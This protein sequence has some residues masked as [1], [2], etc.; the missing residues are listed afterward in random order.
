MTPQHKK[1]LFYAKDRRNRYGENPDASRR[2]I[3]IRKRHARRSRRR[4]ATQELS[5]IHDS[6]ETASDDLPTTVTHAPVQT[7]QKTA[8]TP[9]GEVTMRNLQRNIEK[10]II[11]YHE[12]A[13]DLVGEVIS[14]F[15]ARGE[16]ERT[17]RAMARAIG[18]IVESRGLPGNVRASPEQMRAIWEIIRGILQRH[19]IEP[20]AR[21]RT[22]GR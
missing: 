12:T 1:K 4:N 13:P 7:W 14:R 22:K 3:R 2:G 21:R 19:G 18:S 17:V 20:L 5:G 16:H 9:V 11:R 6:S 15:A 8:D 10:A